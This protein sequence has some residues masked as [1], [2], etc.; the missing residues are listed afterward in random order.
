MRARKKLFNGIPFVVSILSLS[1][2]DACFFFLLLLESRILSDDED[3][4]DDD[5]NDADDG[6]L[7]HGD[8][9]HTQK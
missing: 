5:D 6:D 3:D 9:L 4:D 7:G 2:S 8:F 1:C